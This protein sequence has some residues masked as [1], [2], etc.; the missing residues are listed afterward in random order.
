MNN[1]MFVQQVV[2]LRRRVA[3]LYQASSQ[4]SPSELLAKAFEELQ[5]VLDQLQTAEELLARSQRELSAAR[6]S[7]EQDRQQV[8]DTFN[9]VPTTYVITSTEGTIRRVNQPA[10]CF[11]NQA[12]KLLLGKSL[13]Q[14][15]P[16]GERRAFRSTLAQLVNVEQ[17]TALSLRFQ[18]SSDRPQVCSVVVGAA[19]DRPGRIVAL[20]WLIHQVTPKPDLVTTGLPQSFV[21]GRQFP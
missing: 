15:I 16:D 2:A 1:D 14:F 21:D 7:Q 12:E 6:A 20:H 17:P 19:R 3:A 5:T 8:R 10:T 4:V 9:R 13:N 11:F 18:P